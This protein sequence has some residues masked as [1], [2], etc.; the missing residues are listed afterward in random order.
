MPPAEA[1]IQALHLHS[2]CLCLF[3]ESAETSCSYE[4]AVHFPAGVRSAMVG[5]EWEQ[6]GPHN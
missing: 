5:G 4:A 1:D 2:S 3:V 6:V